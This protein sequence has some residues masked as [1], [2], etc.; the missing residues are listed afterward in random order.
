[1][2]SSKGYEPSLRDRVD[3][4]EHYEDLKKRCTRSHQIALVRWVLAVLITILA[5]FMLT[6]LADKMLAP[7]VVYY[8]LMKKV[9]LSI[10][11]ILLFV[12]AS[13]SLH[14]LT[15]REWKDYL[16]D[17]ERAI[18][19]DRMNETCVGCYPPAEPNNL[20]RIYSDEKCV[21]LI[22]DACVDSGIIMVGGQVEV[23]INTNEK[24][25]RA[26]DDSLAMM[27][28]RQ[29]THHKIFDKSDVFYINSNVELEAGRTLSTTVAET[30]ASNDRPHMLF[31]IDRFYNEGNLDTALMLARRGHSVIALAH[32]HQSPFLYKT[33]E[34][35]L[36]G[37]EEYKRK[38]AMVGFFEEVNLVVMR[39]SASIYRSLDIHPKVTSKL[40]T[41]LCDKGV[42]EAYCYMEDLT[43][44]PQKPPQS[45]H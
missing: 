3:M 36:V 11:L 24:I 32:P 4:N 18:Y 7:S 22:V 23:F 9:F 31:V 14:K 29:I 41:K 27:L 12:F 6:M 25:T 45:R 42:Q 8:I 19:D 30:L 15:Y 40:I 43:T 33:V 20:D 26:P 34:N 28:L 5:V 38:A 35:S 39:D 10:A 44:S 16:S 21:D 37:V 17:E 2:N 1:M 13:K